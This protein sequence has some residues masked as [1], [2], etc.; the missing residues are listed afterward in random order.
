MLSN[1]QIFNANKYYV[2]MDEYLLLTL[3]RSKYQT[4]IEI[5]KDRQKFRHEKISK[6]FESISGE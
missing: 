5:K 3:I 4:P 1:S 6:D 2:A